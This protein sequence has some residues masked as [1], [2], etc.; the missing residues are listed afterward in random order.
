MGLSLWILHFSF[1]FWRLSFSA[2]ANGQVCPDTCVFIFIVS[3]R[4]HDTD[5][6][7]CRSG[8]LRGVLGGRDRWSPRLS[9]PPRYG[10]VLSG[11]GLG[12]LFIILKNVKLI[13]LSGLFSLF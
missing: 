5:H 3:R 8:S 4:E 11:T 6:Q 13:H 10:A 12:P 9:C 2:G 1:L 7:P